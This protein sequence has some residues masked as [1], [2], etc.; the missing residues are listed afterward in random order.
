MMLDN[1]VTNTI[2][3]KISFNWYSILWSEFLSSGSVSI[4]L[5]T[6][7]NDQIKNL[8]STIEPGTLI[9]LV[10]EKG[11]HIYIVGG[12]FYF[13]SM[14]CKAD[15]AWSL[16]GVRNGAKNYDE[17]ISLVNT[18]I[19][20][21][22]EN[23]VC[24]LA[25]NLF[26]FD[27]N[28]KFIMPDELRDKFKTAEYYCLDKN[29]PLALYLNKFV[30]MHRFSF[31]DQ[32]GDNWQGVYKAASARNE[33]NYLPSFRARVFAAY[34]YRCALTGCES[35]VALDAI[36]IQPFYDFTFQGAQNGILLRADI[37]RLFSHGYITF[38]YAD[39]NTVKLKLSECI[40]TAWPDDYICYDE[41]ILNMPDDRSLWPKKEYL[42][43]HQQNCY[44]HWFI[45]GGTH[46]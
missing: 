23:M 12:A 21:A 10:L 29:E 15:E 44:E 34:K 2:V 39:D 17:F 38:Y 7:A 31:L 41:A 40:K 45:Q 24:T 22:N 11:E 3:C 13:R 35:R 33:R 14:F 42:Q 5:W 18:R 36:N 46:I 19:G 8:I 30:L 9:V 37:C 25:D 43:W 6:K 26:L 20:D 32:Y 4:N 1:R 16:F 28:T 27:R